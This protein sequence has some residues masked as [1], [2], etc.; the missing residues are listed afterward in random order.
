MRHHHVDNRVAHKSTGGVP[1]W[2]PQPVDPVGNP[3]PLTSNTVALP[4]RER[5]Q[6]ESET[7]HYQLSASGGFGRGVLNRCQMEIEFVALIQFERGSPS[8]SQNTI[9]SASTKPV[10]RSH[11]ARRRFQPWR[12]L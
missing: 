4:H 9:A 3:V 8:P 12:A 7:G 1:P 2:T 10:A 5:R 11:R 6:S